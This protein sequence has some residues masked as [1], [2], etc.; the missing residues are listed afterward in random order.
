MLRKLEYYTM[1]MYIVCVLYVILWCRKG[2]CGTITKWV[3]TYHGFIHSLLNKVKL[4]VMIAIYND[5]KLIKNT[6][7]IFCNVLALLL[8]RKPYL[9]YDAFTIN[10]VNG[11]IKNTETG[12]WIWKMHSYNIVQ[13]SL[14]VHAQQHWYQEEVIT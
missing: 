1:N 10:Q 11:R 13:R 8:L 5:F 2:M 7:T 12:G 3:L 14:F 9:S 6:A 4:E